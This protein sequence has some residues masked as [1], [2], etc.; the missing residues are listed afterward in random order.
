MNFTIDL[1]DYYIGKW[2]SSNSDPGD[3]AS[4]CWDDGGQCGFG[5]T[6]SDTSLGPGYDNRFA[7]ST[8]YAGFAISTP[9]DRVADE[10]GPVSEGSSHT[11]TY[12][13]SALPTQRPGT[14]YTTFIYYLATANY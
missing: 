1:T 11:I 8:K 10:E 3:W 9:G 4:T 14:S 2:P 12:K 7:T 6:T 13:V 5:Y